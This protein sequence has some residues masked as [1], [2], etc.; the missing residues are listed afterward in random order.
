MA[1]IN[2]SERDFMKLEEKDFIE[3]LSKSS[4]LRVAKRKKKKKKKR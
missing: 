1:G 2:K 4:F 3:F